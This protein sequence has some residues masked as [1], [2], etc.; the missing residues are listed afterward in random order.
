MFIRSQ[1]REAGKETI[2][3]VYAYGDHSISHVSAAKLY[4][5][6]GD[7][8]VCTFAGEEVR[9]GGAFKVLSIEGVE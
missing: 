5:S 6:R 7:C 2:C 3:K 8:H 9:A 4:S 1:A